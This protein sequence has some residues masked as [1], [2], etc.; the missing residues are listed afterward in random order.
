MFVHDPIVGKQRVFTGTI[1]GKRQTFGIAV[2]VKGP[3]YWI[4]SGASILVLLGCLLLLFCWLLYRRAWGRRLAGFKPAYVK[5][6]RHRTVAN[7]A[8]LNERPEYLRALATTPEWRD[9]IKMSVDYKRSA[10]T[11]LK[12]I[13]SRKLLTP[14]L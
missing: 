4:L 14:F 6:R 13:R 1:R 11:A 10:E 3:D 9:H 12:G 7:D 8:E 2:P 5:I